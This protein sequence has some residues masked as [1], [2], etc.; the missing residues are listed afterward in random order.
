MKKENISDDRFSNKIQLKFKAI[1]DIIKS[2]KFYLITFTD[3]DE[4]N[5]RT[6]YNINADDIHDK[7]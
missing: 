1:I 3:D 7:I 5:W 4:V 2:K 6:Q